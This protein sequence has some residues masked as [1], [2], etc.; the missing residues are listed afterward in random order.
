MGPGRWGSR[1]DIKLGVSVTYS[2]INNTAMLIEIARKKGNYV[3]DLSFGTHFFQDLV[4]SSI[5]YL[6]LYPD[7]QG[8]VFNEHFLLAS[9][10]FLPEIL[11][12]FA[13][14]WPI[15]CASST[16][17]A[18][19]SGKVLRVLM[20]ADLDEAV[21]FLATPGPPAPPRRK[22]GNR[23]RPPARITGAGGCGW[24]SASRRSSTPPAS[25]S[26]AFY[27]F[28]STKNATA[29]PGSDIDMLVHFAGTRGAATGARAMARGLE[30]V[31]GRD[32]LPAPATSRAVCSTCTSS[33]TRTSPRRPATRSRSAPS[34]TRP[35]GCP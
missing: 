5:R 19:T 32:E 28:G 14:L 11:P 33:P 18:S 17:R 23:R 7:D 6:P 20:N 30:P 27:V 2:D 3:P 21:G 10:K 22:R 34:P 15:P 8:I 35:A 25:A 26:K 12:E 24:P 9:P 13:R 4:E 16:S 31:P 29:G 1:G